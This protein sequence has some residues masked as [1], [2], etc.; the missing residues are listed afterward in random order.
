MSFKLPIKSLSSCQLLNLRQLQHGCAWLQVKMLRGMD[1]N[2]A[3]FYIG[4]IVLALEYLHENNIIYRD[5]KPENVFIDQQG[6]VKL[7]D[8]GFAKVTAVTHLPIDRISV[9]TEQ[10]SLCSILAYGSMHL[11]E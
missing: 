9:T 6:F 10:C 7:G 8:F 2:L 4:C 5:L 3:K 11:C 1:E